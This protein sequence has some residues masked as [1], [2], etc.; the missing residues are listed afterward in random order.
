MR[1]DVLR[2]ALECRNEDVKDLLSVLMLMWDS[3]TVLI[4]KED[5]REYLSFHYPEKLLALNDAMA[6]S[7][8]VLED[9]KLRENLVIRKGKIIHERTAR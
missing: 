4:E 1:K 2:E 5:V 7:R 9:A 6:A 3:F 8:T